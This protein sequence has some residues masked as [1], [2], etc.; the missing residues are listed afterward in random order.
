MFLTQSVSYSAA[1]LAGLLS[2]VSPCLLPLIPAYFAFISGYSIE[3]LT[4]NPDA[5]VR[6]RIFT[7]TISF[8]LG[9]SL[10]FILMG[11]SASVIG[12]MVVQYK[13]VIRII[14]GLLIIGLG[15]HMTGL[16]RIGALETDKRL[17]VRRKPLHLVGIFIVGMAFAAGWSPC[18]GPLLGS[19]LMVA[20]TSETVGQG[21]WLLAVYSAGLAVPFILISIF[22]PAM[23]RI[24]RGASKTL[25]YAGPVA[26][27]LLIL[28][29]LLLLTDSFG[30]FIVA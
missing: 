14:G 3:E 2:F 11:A 17:S 23:L 29:G 19:I 9:F 28:V 4:E 5:A 26:G 8:V 16:I 15:I 13:D 1:F 20:G 6:A 24:V 7:A 12:S 27:A 10:V 22:V 30:F 21:V 25:R 18:I